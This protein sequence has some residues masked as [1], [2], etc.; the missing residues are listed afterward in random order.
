[1]DTNP[2]KRI[3]QDVHPRVAGD[4]PTGAEGVKKAENRQQGGLSMLSHHRFNQIRALRDEGLCPSAIARRLGMDRK[5]V[6]K[7]VNSNSPP[8]YSPRLARTRPDPLG[9]FDL[10][11]RAL[12]EPVK[13]DKTLTYTAREIFELIQSEGY[14]GS[15]R[16]VDRRV[17]ALRGEKPKERFFEQQYEPG[18]QSQFDFKESVE[19]PFAGG[20]R[21]VHLHFGTLPHSDF[22]FVRAY[23]FKTYECFM[24]GIHRFFEQIGGQT[25]AIRIDNLSPCVSKVLTGDKRVWTQAFGRAIAH[26]DFKV[27]PCRPGKGSDKGD[28]ERDIRTFANRI[29]RLVRNQGT[30]FRDWEHLNGWL[31]DYMDSRRQEETLKKLVDERKHL[32]PLAWADESVLCKIEESRATAHGTFRINKTAYS[33]PDEAIGVQ[34]RAIMGPYEVKIYRLEGGKKWVATHPRTTEGDSSILLAHV[35]PSLLRKPHALIRWAHR[36]ILFPKPAFRAFYQKLRGVDETAAPREFLRSV[37]LVQLVQLSEIEAGMELLMES[38]S[39]EPLFDQLRE[40]LFGS[41]QPAQVYELN[42][43]F[44]QKPLQPELAVYDQLIPRNEKQS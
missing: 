21:I 14:R 3:P 43:R 6:T 27:L 38:Q 30:V 35:L 12:S 16:T 18:E 19:L 40:L 25:A 4:T 26:Y 8:R 17:A 7:Y 34:C 20:P 36:E 13:E 22:C 15:E 33:V 37:N 44:N 10:R 5:T 1:M 29:R 9:A 2:P 24:D 32:K 11:V 31:M 42:R 28:V 23:P 41:R 39:T